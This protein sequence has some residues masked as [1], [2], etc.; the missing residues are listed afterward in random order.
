MEVCPLILLQWQK[1]NCQGKSLPDTHTDLLQTQ[2]WTC[3]PIVCKLRHWLRWHYRQILRQYLCHSILNIIQFEAELKKETA[4]QFKV[5]SFLNRL[6]RKNFELHISR[7]I[8][9]YRI[10]LKSVP[11]SV[12]VNELELKKFD[13]ENQGVI[14]QLI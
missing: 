8:D 14:F 6:L 13:L 3:L 10:L 9:S 12:L 5:I 2:C 1:Q 4:F 11:E 7:V